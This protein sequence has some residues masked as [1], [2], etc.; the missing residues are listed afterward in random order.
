MHGVYYFGETLPGVNV[1]DFLIRRCL[2]NALR[3]HF[4]S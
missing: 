4:K 2:L 3:K 1:H